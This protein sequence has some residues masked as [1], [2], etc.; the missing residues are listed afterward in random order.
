VKI[1]AH[2]MPSHSSK[3]SAIYARKSL[4]QMDQQ[5]PTYIGFI[6]SMDDA[7]IVA[8]ACLR[9][10]LSPITSRYKQPIKDGDCFVFIDQKSNIK[11]WTDGKIWSPSRH[12]G[13]FLVYRELETV[14][15]NSHKR[16]ISRVKDDGLIKKTASVEIRGWKCHIICYYTNSHECDAPSRDPNLPPLLEGYNLVS[17][18]T[19]PGTSNSFSIKRATG[20]KRKRSDNEV[21]CNDDCPQLTQFP[22]DYFI[23]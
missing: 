4:I 2:K 16:N 18:S 1:T 23:F 14:D 22:C 21:S 17:N 19:T 7:A 8:N 10:L 11:R 13:N 15:N 9:G 20:A 3:I 5:Q 12:S 6:E